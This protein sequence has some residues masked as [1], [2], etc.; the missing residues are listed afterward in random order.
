MRGSAPLTMIR[1]ALLYFDITLVFSAQLANPLRGIYT[2]L[3]AFLRLNLPM[4]LEEFQTFT[5]EVR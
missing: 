5:N 3:A 1:A 2:Q 4:S